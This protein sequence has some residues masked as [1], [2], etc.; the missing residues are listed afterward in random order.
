MHKRPKNLELATVSHLAEWLA[1]CRGGKP[2]WSNFNYGAP[3][4]EFLLL[5]NIATQVDHGF[6]FDPLACRIVHGEAADNLLRR[7]YREGW[8]L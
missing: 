1:A 7:R 5:G 2:A 6:E 4:T 3:L 8:S